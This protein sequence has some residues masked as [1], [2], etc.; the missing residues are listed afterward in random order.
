M[1]ENTLT[2]GNNFQLVMQLGQKTVD[3]GISVPID[4]KTIKLEGPD[5][6]KN[7]GLTL[8]NVVK[9]VQDVVQDILNRGQGC[10]DFITH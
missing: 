5:T 9:A 10:V 4:I 1:K 7:K 2:I 6:K 8:K 3:R